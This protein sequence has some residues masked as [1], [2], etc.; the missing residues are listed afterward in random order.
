MILLSCFFHMGNSFGM[1]DII[2]SKFDKEYAT[3][4][5]AERDY[6]AE[7]GV[8]FSFVKKINGIN[9]F[10]YTKTY[11]LFKNLADFYE[12]VYSK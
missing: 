11:E 9:T 3:Q 12:D 10:K 7:H 2:N 6:L 1:E 8:N 5:T 4:W